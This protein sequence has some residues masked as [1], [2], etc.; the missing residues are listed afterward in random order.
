MCKWEVFQIN[1]V[2]KEEDEEHLFLNGYNLTSYT[3]QDTQTS[4]FKMRTY[5]FVKQELKIQPWKL[6]LKCFRPSAHY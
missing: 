4:Y 1:S 5:S 2:E 3:I 6:L